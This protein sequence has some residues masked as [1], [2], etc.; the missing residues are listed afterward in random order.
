MDE[1]QWNKM[2]EIFETARKMKEGKIPVK[3]FD[4]IE[5]FINAMKKTK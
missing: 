2:Q 1:S 5:S 3:H 4:S